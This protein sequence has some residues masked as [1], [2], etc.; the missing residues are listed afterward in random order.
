LDYVL[1]GLATPPGDFGLLYAMV[2]DG[3]RIVSS[4]TKTGGD[5]TILAA[6]NV[7]DAADAGVLDNME[8]FVS[9]QRKPPFIIWGLHVADDL[10]LA[11][12]ENDAVD[13]YA[14]VGDARRI[15][16][17]RHPARALDAKLHNQTI[18]VGC[19]YGYMVLW[20]LE[21]VTS[22]E[23]ATDE[24]AVDKAMAVIS[25]HPAAIAKMIILK[26]EIISG[27]YNGNIIVRKLNNV[28]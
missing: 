27:D 17:L 28:L 2:C 3:K 19:Q 10:V 8:H 4:Y 15:R 24:M 18:F 21:E 14:L 26:D 6:F 13:V 22:P 11:C 5:C 9:D 20:R 1:D 7:S 12:H 25:A 16:T 23:T